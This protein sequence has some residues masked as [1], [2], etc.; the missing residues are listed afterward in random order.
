MSQMK[1]IGFIGP[2]RT[3]KD[4]FFDNRGNMFALC[5]DN[6]IW[7]LSYMLDP[8]DVMIGVCSEE[9][10]EKFGWKAMPRIPG[11]VAIEIK[12]KDNENA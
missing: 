1:I 9:L 3:V 8:Q 4:I 5:D 12:G 10:E 11:T 7:G 6:T 2:E